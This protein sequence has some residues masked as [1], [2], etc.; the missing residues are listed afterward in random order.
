MP[1]PVY[2]HGG[3]SS[4]G[5]PSVPGTTTNSG[6][7][8]LIAGQIYQSAMHGFFLGTSCTVVVEVNGGNCDP[9]TG[10]P[11]STDWID[12]TSGGIALTTGQNFAKVLPKQEVY[13]RTRIT[14]ITLGG[15]AG[16]WSY[17][18]GV[19]GPGGVTTAGRPPTTSIAYNPNA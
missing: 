5:W 12:I 2:S 15:G 6:N 11:T 10:Q 14:A 17:V 4:P 18:P 7:P 1:T 3:P 8:I 13:V 16:F 9:Q 19:A